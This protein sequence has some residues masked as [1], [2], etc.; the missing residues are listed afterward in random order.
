M[1]KK[2]KEIEENKD[3][4]EEATV[5]TQPKQGIVSRGIS[6]VKDHKGIFA[7]IGGT[8]VGTGLGF[9]LATILA[10]RDD[11]DPEYEPYDEDDFNDKDDSGEDE[12]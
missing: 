10:G 9:G 4:T 3:N 8:I 7:T 5:D 11:E 2:I 1:S 6:W 12:E